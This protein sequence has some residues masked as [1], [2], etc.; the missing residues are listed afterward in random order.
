MS[1]LNN[2][3][4]DEKR[5]DPLRKLEKGELIRKAI[6]LGLGLNI[7]SPEW[8]MQQFNELGLDHDYFLEAIKKLS[9]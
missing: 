8:E 7:H 1:M 6:G 4:C 3:G 5:S 9:S 2:V